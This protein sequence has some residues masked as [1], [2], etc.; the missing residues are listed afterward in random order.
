MGQEKNI[1]LKEVYYSKVLSW[2]RQ[3]DSLGKGKNIHVFG[4]WITM[5]L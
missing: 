5:G 1:L 4:R 3:L 2:K